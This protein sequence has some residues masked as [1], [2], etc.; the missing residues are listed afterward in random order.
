MFE[1]MNPLDRST[2]WL[3][4]FILMFVTFIIGFLFGWWYFRHKF[5]GY[6]DQPNAFKGYEIMHEDSGALAESEGIKAVKTRNRGG[7]MVTDVNDELSANET[8]P[9]IDFNEIGKIIE[10][11]DLKLI[12]GIGPTLETKLNKIGIYT[13][14]QIGSFSEDDIREITKL[15]EYSFRRIIRDNWVGQAKKLMV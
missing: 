15:I 7:V 12:N 6:K 9:P 4:I 5:K 1:S 2:A 3:E 14:D 10:K 8:R 13:F 11:D